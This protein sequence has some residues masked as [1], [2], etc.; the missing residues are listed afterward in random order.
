MSPVL[1]PSSFEPQTRPDGD[2]DYDG[3]EVGDAGSGLAGKRQSSGGLRRG[4]AIRG[5]DAALVGEP[6]CR[7]RGE[8][9]A[10]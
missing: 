2:L 4:Q 10:S 1:P 7:R 5:L 8:A 3:S 9:R 6:R